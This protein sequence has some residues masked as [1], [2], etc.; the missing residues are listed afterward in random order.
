MSYQVW[1]TDGYGFCVDHIHTSPRRVMALAATNAETLKYVHKYL[2]DYMEEE[3][4]ISN[5]E[6]DDLQMSDFNDLCDDCGCARGVAYILS[7][8]IKYPVIIVDNFEGEQYIL[9]CPEFPWYMPKEMQGVTE[10]DIRDEFQRCISV[11]T[12]EDIYIDYQSVPNGG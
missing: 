12:D 2:D 8:V 5:W 6:V 1:S 11:L 7:D 9:L 10:K 4:C 3:H